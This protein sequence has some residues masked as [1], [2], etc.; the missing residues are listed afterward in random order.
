M[1]AA[2]S[3]QQ[4]MNTKNLVDLSSSEEYESNNSNR[5]NNS[6][7]EFVE[8]DEL[9]NDKDA[10]SIIDRLL[11]ASEASF[12]KKRQLKL[13]TGLSARTHQRKNKILKEAAARSLKI[14]SFFCTTNTQL[15][16]AD[17]EDIE[18]HNGQG[19]MK[20]SETVAKVINGGPWLAKCI[21]KWANICI[22]EELISL[23]LR[24]KLPTKSPLHNKFVSLQ[25]ATYLP[26]QKFKATPELV[27]NYYDQHILPRLNIRPVQHISVQTVRPL[28]DDQEEARV[29]MVL[30][31]VGL[32][33]F[34][35]A[36]SHT[37]FAED[38]LVAS[39]MNLSP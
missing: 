13:Y 4:A 28:K 34:N 38:A 32:F 5:D 15:P 18:D 17:E 36:T 33:A 26:T 19:K 6:D 2:R 20:A 30:G 39:K 1:N 31:C 27:K 3:A 37:A 14:T 9:D 11:A 35:N 21:R 22:I 10:S 24:G 12:E 29:M 16:A 7:D 25:L 8:D 23:S